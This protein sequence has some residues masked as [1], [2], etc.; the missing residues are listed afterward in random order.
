MVYMARRSRGVSTFA[1]PVDFSSQNITIELDRTNMSI[2][3]RYVRLLA[4]LEVVLA[5]ALHCDSSVVQVLRL[6][7]VH[8]SVPF[9]FD[10]EVGKGQMLV[11]D[12]EAR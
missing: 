6:C 8:G 7:L 9:H 2:I 4:N 1:Y 5:L 3:P 11:K 10:Y 12:C